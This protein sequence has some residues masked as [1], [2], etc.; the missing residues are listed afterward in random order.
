MPKKYMGMILPPGSGWWVLKES[1]EGT[2]EN[3]ESNRQQLLNIEEK[4]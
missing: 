3:K 2:R 1:C 4:N